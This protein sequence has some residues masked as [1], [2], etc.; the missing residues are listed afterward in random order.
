M[1]LFALIA[2]LSIAVTA[3]ATDLNK[4]V[5]RVGRGT[6]LLAATYYTSRN[7]GQS[8]YSC[9]FFKIKID[10]RVNGQLI[11]ADAYE[12]GLNPAP[13]LSAEVVSGP[14]GK[15]YGLRGFVIYADDKLN[16]GKQFSITD[17][18]VRIETGYGNW[19]SGNQPWFQECSNIH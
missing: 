5:G 19:A 3:H 2:L 14:D 7:E 10:V 15:E 18:S 8:D 1:K 16:S 13:R 9:S 6:D 4:F 12:L 17:D 11:S